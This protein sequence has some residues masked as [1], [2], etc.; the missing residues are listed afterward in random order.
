MTWRWLC[1]LVILTVTAGGW[2]EGGRPLADF[3]LTDHYGKP[4]SWQQV[5]GKVALV[6]FGYTSC[7]DV[8]PMTLAVVAQTLKKL[9]GNAER[10]APL[11]ISVD[12][13][14]D[15][16]ENLRS[17]VG[18]FDPRIIGLTGSAAQIATAASRFRVSFGPNPRASGTSRTVD[19]TASLFVVGADGA[20][21][22]SV[23]FGFPADHV[24]Q[25]VMAQLAQMP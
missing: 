4:W 24:V 15:T 11:F 25:V 17:Y 2:A 16:P 1:S 12:P 6:A 8:C 21:A 19:H 9:G 22:V 14:R 13:A 20:I 18:Y 3:T 23:P 10:V 5:R 7:P